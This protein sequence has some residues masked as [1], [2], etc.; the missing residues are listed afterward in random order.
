MPR[1]SMPRHTRRQRQPP[2]PR[3]RRPDASVMSFAVG[4]PSSQLRGTRPLP[5]LA[6]LESLLPSTNFTALQSTETGLP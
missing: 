1:V 3:G 4:L 6:A 2:V 5:T